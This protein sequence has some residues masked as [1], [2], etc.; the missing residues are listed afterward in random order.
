M[1]V[2][3]A[4][5]LLLVPALHAGT[6]VEWVAS[7]WPGPGN[8]WVSRT[9]NQS[10]FYDT[11][12]GSAPQKGTGTLYGATIA[13]VVFDGNDFLT[14][15]LEQYNRS[16]AGLSELSLTVVFRSETPK[17]A[18]STD[19]HAFWNFKG[20]LG[21]DVSE[22]DGGEF[23]IGVWDDGTKQGAVAAAA[24]LADDVGLSAGALNDGAWHVVTLVIARQGES[25]FSQSVY[26][27]N[28]LVRSENKL[29][30]STGSNATVVANQPFSVGQIRS[31]ANSPFTGS[32]AAIRL[33]TSALSATEIGQLHRT[34]LGL[35]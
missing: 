11:Y 32:I 18:A 22:P 26:A 19:V 28:R 24:G 14:T 35:K 2:W 4:A 17:A 13:T 25:S 9:G 16:W 33:D 10:F 12:G 27:D 23:A 21:F 15:P 30:Y 8:D 3:M 1:P 20:I 7:D 34:Y 29:S 5:L 31:G 6:V